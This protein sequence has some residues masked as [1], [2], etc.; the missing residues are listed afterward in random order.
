VRRFILMLFFAAGCAALRTPESVGP[1]A[2][3]Q[4]AS[5]RPVEKIEQP[6][7]QEKAAEPATAAA[8]P[9]RPAAPNELS[10]AHREPA[11]QEPANPPHTVKEASVPGSKLLSFAKLAET[12]DENILHVYTGMYRKTVEGIMGKVQN[13]YKRQKITSADGKVYEVLFYLTREPRKGRPITDRMLSPLIF[14]KGRVVAIGNYSLKKL[15]LIGS[16]GRQKT[17]KR[18]SLPAPE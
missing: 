9:S 18:T 10:V 13:P 6:A 15:I 14:R 3:L 16:L 1:G 8:E 12:N 5:A 2:V 4:P 17:A 11:L 7:I